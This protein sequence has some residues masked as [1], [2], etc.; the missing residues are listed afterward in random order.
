MKICIVSVVNIKHM[1]LISHYTSILEKKNIPYDI[2]YIDKYNEDEKINAQNKYVFKLNID[3]SWS[4][5]KKFFQYFK[6]RKYVKEIL[7]KNEYDLLIVWRTET[8]LLLFDYLL[9]KYKNKFIL[10]VRDYCFEKN[11][12]VYKV[13]TKLIENSRLTTISS[14]G[15]RKF[16]PISQYQLLH[17][18]NNQLLEK[19]E[20]RRRFRNKNEPIRICFIGYV[21]FFDND[22]R[23]L[24]T[25]ANDER[26]IIQYFGSGSE[27]LQDYCLENNIRNVEFYGKFSVEETAKFLQNADVI[28]NLYGYNNIAL[29]TAVSIKY[30]YALHLRLPILVYDNTHMSE[31]TKSIG[32]G[33]SINQSMSNLPDDFFNWYHNLD[34]DKINENCKNEVFKINKNNHEFQKEFEDILG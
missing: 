7:S 13:I 23:L 10:N 29:D 12:L 21:R 34:F 32:I 6:F 19:M 25:F 8:A 11:P 5:S 17:S 1:S 26:Y 3:R 30:Y 33:Y 22:K 28:N 14:E 9:R 27:I 20:P 15:F 2:I 4:K 24:D 16:L 31:I 18:Y